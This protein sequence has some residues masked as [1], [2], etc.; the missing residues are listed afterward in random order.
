MSSSE[1]NGV[2]IGLRSVHTARVLDERPEVPWW[3][4]LYDNFQAD[5]GPAPRVLERVRALYRVAFHCVG[6]D[7]GSVDA[8]NMEYVS[9]LKR[10]A[11]R[12][13]PELVSC[14]LC[15]TA[16]DDIFLHDLLPLPYTEEAVRHVT[17]R[18]TRYQDVLGRRILIENV[19]TYLRFADSQM[20]E[21]E[22]LRAVAEAAD[23]L[24]LFDVNNAYVNHRNLDEDLEAMLG[25][26]PPERIGQMHLG[27]YEEQS[28]GLLLDTHGADVPDPVW[29][30]FAA[31][32]QR[33]PDVP[34]CIE[35]DN[36]I[37]PL[38]DLLAERQ[39]AEDIRQTV[40]LEGAR[41]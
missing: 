30:V 28:D 32:T 29:D 35:R 41:G 8:P 18:I 1:L 40:A 39:R 33:F 19:S 7:V 26:L 22:F 23:C 11:D 9:R 6:L 3:E 16:V 27:G 21:A 17:D 2:G 10:M 24:I 31:A 36:N 4:V 34:V 37:P 14:H 25:T 5:G 15:W 20:T 38:D 13:E 12:F